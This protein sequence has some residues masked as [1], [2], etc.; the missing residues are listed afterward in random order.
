VCLA[1]RPEV[2]LD[3]QVQL[4]PE[5]AE[6]ATSALSQLRRLVYL[7]QAQDAGIEGTQRVFGFGRAAQLDVMDQ[8]SSSLAS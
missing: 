3:A 2:C 8:Q 7:G 5:P 1:C 4:D 6:P